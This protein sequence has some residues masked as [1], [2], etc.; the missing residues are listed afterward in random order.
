MITLQKSRPLL[1]GV[2]R[3]QYIYLHTGTYTDIIRTVKPASP[4]SFPGFNQLIRYTHTVHI[5]VYNLDVDIFSLAAS[6]C[7]GL[8]LPKGGKHFSLACIE[9][10]VSYLP[11]TVVEKSERR[12]G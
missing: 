8:F 1:G 6:I 5:P 12:H 9:G 11:V 10:Q 4:S 7:L 3:M 2:H